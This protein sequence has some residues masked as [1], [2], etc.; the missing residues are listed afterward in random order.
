LFIFLKGCITREDIT[1]LI[2]GHILLV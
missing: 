1:G 2:R